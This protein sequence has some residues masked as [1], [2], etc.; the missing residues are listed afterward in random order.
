[1]LEAH[2]H[3]KRRFYVYKPLEFMIR[4]WGGSVRA[5]VVGALALVVV[6]VLVVL[7][8]TVGFKLPGAI[9]IFMVLQYPPLLPLVIMH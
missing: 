2:K 5:V 4:F 6:E 7:G 8:G 9:K 3:S 1:M